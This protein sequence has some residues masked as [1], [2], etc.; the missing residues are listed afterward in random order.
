MSNT[1]F[2]PVDK[3]AVEV[4]EHTIFFTHHDDNFGLGILY[5]FDSYDA[6]DE[7][8]H[9]SPV[10]LEHLCKALVAVQLYTLLI[11]YKWKRVVEIVSSRDRTGAYV[12]FRSK[13]DAMLFKLAN[14]GAA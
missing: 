9:G 11:G 12:E 2:V 10:G 1:L 4:A 8:E 7:N 14:G 5:E 13:A 3:K 6:D